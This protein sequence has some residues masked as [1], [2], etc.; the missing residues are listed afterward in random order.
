[1]LLGGANLLLLDGPTNH[2]DIASVEWLEDF[3]KNY[4]GAYLVI[5]HDRYFLDKITSRTFEL[6]NKKL[7]VYKGNYTAFLAQKRSAAFPGAAVRQYHAGIAR[8]EGVVAQQRQWNREKNIR[9]AES[10][11]KVIE[12]LERDLEKAGARPR[13]HPFPFRHPPDGRQRR[14][15]GRRPRLRL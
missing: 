6:E 5:S 8:L 7:T 3:L 12:R 4:R 1:M 13:V 14:T 2:L 15:D 10:K 11:L 9:T